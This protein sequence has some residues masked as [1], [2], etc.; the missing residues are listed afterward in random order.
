[1]KDYQ[2]ELE[3]A[4]MSRDDAAASAKEAEKKVK[5]LEAEL[6]QLHEDLA[7]SERARK[8]VEGE[9]D[10]LQDEINNSGASK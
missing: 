3:D 4:M 9:R 8:V 7:A 5:N 6:L 10:E 2:R 1:M